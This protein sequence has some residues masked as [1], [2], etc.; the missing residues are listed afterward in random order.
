[1]DKN[2]R[3]QQ[4]CRYYEKEGTCPYGNLCKFRH[5]VQKG[6]SVRKTEYKERGQQQDQ[7]IKAQAQDEKMSFLYNQLCRQI[8]H[9]SQKIDLMQ[10]AFYQIR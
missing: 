4:V 3:N 5:Y 10:P 6:D 2:M 7:E 9:L 1:M 8:N